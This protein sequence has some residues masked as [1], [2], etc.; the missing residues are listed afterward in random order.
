MEQHLAGTQLP[1]RRTV[2]YIEKDI[3]GGRIKQHGA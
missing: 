3:T 1:Q 2:E